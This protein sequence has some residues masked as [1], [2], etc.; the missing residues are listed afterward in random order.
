[1]GGPTQSFF[2]Q[3]NFWNRQHAEYLGFDRPDF[4][5]LSPKVGLDQISHYWNY[6]VFSVI[7]STCH[8]Q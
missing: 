5:L 4:N 6:I 3:M 8:S 1:M 2:G 7:N